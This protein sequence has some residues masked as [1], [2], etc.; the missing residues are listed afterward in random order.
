MSKPPTTN[1]LNT[2]STKPVPSMNSPASSMVDIEKDCALSSVLAKAAYFGP[3]PF[4]LFK[5]YGI[6]RE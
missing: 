6:K 2:P 3:A 4:T 1:S 5:I